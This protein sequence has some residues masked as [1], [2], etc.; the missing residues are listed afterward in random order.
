MH[1]QPGTWRKVFGDDADEFFHA[2]SIA[3]Y[4][5]EIAAAGKSIKPLP[6]YM[7][8]ALASA[9]GRQA[10]RRLIQAADRFSS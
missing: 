3:S 8:A 4:V 7:N 5:N 9:F 10:R 2:W 6:M 1:K